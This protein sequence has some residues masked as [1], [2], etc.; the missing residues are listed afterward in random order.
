MTSSDRDP[1]SDLFEGN[2]RDLDPTLAARLLSDPY[3]A[4]S[5]ENPDVFLNILE[6]TVH[7][8]RKLV[9]RAGMT[10]SNRPHKREPLARQEVSG[11]FDAR[12]ADFIARFF[13]NSA[14][15]SDGVKGLGEIVCYFA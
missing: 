8:L 13:W 15:R 10:G 6:V 7:H 4:V 12:E 5:L 11:G 1:K 9:E 2:L 14:T 3:K